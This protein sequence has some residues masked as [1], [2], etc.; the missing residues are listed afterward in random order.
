MHFLFG[1]VNLDWK[2][3]VAASLLTWIACFLIHEAWVKGFITRHG[4]VRQF[5]QE[6]DCRRLSAVVSFFLFLHFW[7]ACIYRAYVDIYGVSAYGLTSIYI[8]VFATLYALTTIISKESWGNIAKGGSWIGEKWPDLLA[9]IMNLREKQN[10]NWHICNWSHCQSLS[11][12]KSSEGKLGKWA[13]SL[14]HRCEELY[15]S[16]LLPTLLI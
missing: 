12:K 11:T 3:F 7:Y 9:K 8:G 4:N 14:T 15:F 1:G 5:Q 6:D 10:V 13:P 2:N 16:F